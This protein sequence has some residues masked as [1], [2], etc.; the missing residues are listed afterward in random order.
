MSLGE[1]FFNGAVL[2]SAFPAL[3]RGLVTT[4]L[5]GSASILCGTSAG[6]VVALARLYGRAPL[7]LAATLYADVFRALPMLVVL[8]VIYYALPFVGIRLDGW[9]S[10]ILGFSLVL[11]AYAAEV[12]RA[13]I[14]AVPKG[15]F[16]AAAA[17]GLP[18]PLALAK[19]VLPPGAAAR[20]AAGHLERGVDDQGHLARLRRRAA[21]A[22][23]GGAGFP[24]AQRQP[25][26]ADRGGAD[27][28]GAAVAAGAPRRPAR[29][30]GAGTGAVG[31]HSPRP[32]QP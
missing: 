28:P 6:L 24:G 3:L 21:R 11:A 32:W 8:M 10:A 4:L 19:V 22:P 1:T 9:T 20:R 2:A 14:E 29:G 17:L 15:Q 12:F 31:Y 27:L 30:A 23:E 7:R 5:L 18:F 13:G 16:E 26:P 25:H